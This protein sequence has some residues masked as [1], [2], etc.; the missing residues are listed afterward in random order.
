MYLGQYRFI[1][2]LFRFPICKHVFD[3]SFY[4]KFIYSKSLVQLYI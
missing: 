1:L 4:A 2:L 3:I